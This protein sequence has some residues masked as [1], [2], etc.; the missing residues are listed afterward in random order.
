MKLSFTPSWLLAFAGA[1][2]AL[3]QAASA[4]AKPAPTR[5]LFVGNSFLHG[6]YEPVLNYNSANVKDENFG[7][8]AGDPRAEPTDKEP[9]PWGGIPGIF[10]KMTDEAGLNYE[11]HFESISGKTLKYHY[12]NALGVIQ[13]PNWQAVVMHDNS[14]WPLPARR[15]GHPGEFREYAAKLEQAIHSASPAA[16]VYL[17]ETWARADL[18]YPAGKA[19]VGLPID[20]MA[21]DLHNGYYGMLLQDPKLAGVVPAG[22]AWVRAI[23]TGVAMPNPYTPETGKLDLWAIDH[24]HPSKWGAYLN[25]CVLFGELTGRDP[26]TLGASEQAASALGIT[27]ADAVNLQRVAAEQVLAAR[28]AAFAGPP[29]KAGRPGAQPE[30]GP[31]KVKV[32]RKK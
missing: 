11:V 10:K 8:P 14:A 9:G 23:Q 17:Y 20:S 25:A 27:P 16:K 18:T 28:P 24:Y 32:K 15:T 5:I 12:E 19:Y 3:P 6:K 21:Q 7:R 30:S 2:W 31:A 22:D 29:T 13:Q 4:Q 1:F 26:R